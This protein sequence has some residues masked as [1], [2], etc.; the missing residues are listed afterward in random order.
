MASGKR[1]AVAQ[2]GERADVAS[3]RP[4]VRMGV[5]YIL[6]SPSTGKYYVEST[7]DLIKRLNEHHAGHVKATR[8]LRPL[9]LV[10]HQSFDNA[11]KARQIEYRL[12]Q[13]KSKSVIDRIIQD[14]YIRLKIGD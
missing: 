6:K 1:G 11:R 14:G 13:F 10:F 3:A 8:L 5:V 7:I 2:L 4:G 12:K 9:E